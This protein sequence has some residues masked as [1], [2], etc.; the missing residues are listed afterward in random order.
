MTSA[1]GSDKPV[2]IRTLTKDEITSRCEICGQIALWIAES[3]L[4]GATAAYCQTD[5]QM[6]LND[7]DYEVPAQL[8]ADRK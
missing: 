4:T 7:P 8:R 6:F 5:I 1:G 3:R 2:F